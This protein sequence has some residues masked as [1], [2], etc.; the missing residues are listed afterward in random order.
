[1]LVYDSH[2]HLKHGDAAA[3]EY[4]PD[5]IVE[6]MDAAGIEK[7][8]VFAMSTSTDRSV[9][10]ARAAVEAFPGRL[11]PYVY[12][13][14]A[15]GKAVLPAIRRAVTELGFRGIK[16][17]A[18]E[19]RLT[20]YV[21]DPVF[22]LAG[23]LGVPCLVD[24]SGDLAAAKRLATAFPYTSIIVAHLGQYLCTVPERLDGFIE[25]AEACD[26]VC[27]DASG[28]ALVW[29]IEDAVRRVGSDRVL[30]G[31]DGPHPAP[32]TAS[33]ARREVRKFEVLNLTAAQKEDVF[34][35]TL[36]RLAKIE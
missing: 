11:V 3:T 35:G 10:M 20:E 1:M 23:Q 9:E 24:F 26:N 28:V 2:A 29:K 5:A 25:L 15:Y 16:L 17:H 22:S 36:R 13:L 27:L 14:P 6:A 7:S 31:T 32:D 34:A 33:F 21:V 8:V 4:G 30:F 18:A 12:A 19:C